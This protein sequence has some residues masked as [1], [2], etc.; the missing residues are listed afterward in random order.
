M[1]QPT[2]S[3]IVPCYKLA[4]LLPTCVESILSQS[5][6]DFEILIMD[7]CSPDETMEA[8]RSFKDNRV[9]PIRNERNLGHLRNYNKGIELARGNYLWLI[10]ADDYLFRPYVLERYVEVMERHP[11]VGYA[12]CA[13]VE[14]QDASDATSVI[15]Y[16]RYS[17]RDQV[18]DGH[19]FLKRLLHHNFVLA[20][21]GLVRKECYDRLGAF[22]LD[23]PWAGDWYL[24]CLFALHFDVAYF[25]EPMVCYRKHE[26]S[27]T[28]W[29][30]SKKARACC[31]EE[32][33]IGWTIKRKAAEGGLPHVA[34]M[35]MEGLGQVYARN[36]VPN[37]WTGP[38]PILTL[39]ELEESLAKY[40]HD[41]RERRFVR[42]R[43][44]ARMGDEYHQRGERDQAGHFYDRAL[45]EDASM[46]NMRVKRWLLH[47]GK[48]GDTVRG[49]AQKFA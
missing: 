25:A 12:C 6:G 43:V 21:S 35:A 9:K 16:S 7:D 46:L 13:G 45:D 19:R 37:A 27:M 18:V 32:F 11:S 39:D 31:E 3:F 44:Y 15:G 22:P 49:W 36:M 48:T 24:W 38:V 20:A 1:P 42:S 10:S 4:H 41:K 8:A 23:M 40:C 29:L 30:T 17:K 2:V 14:L 26:L 5:F 47:L 33:L 28:S 34:R